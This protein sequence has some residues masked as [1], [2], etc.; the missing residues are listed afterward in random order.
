MP[1]VNIKTD[2][3]LQAN[4]I[5]MIAENGRLA[6]ILNQEIIRRNFQETVPPFEDYAEV[7]M[8]EFSTNNPQHEVYFVQE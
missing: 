3:V 8:D 1:Q 7:V 6:E 5:A 2:N 4:F